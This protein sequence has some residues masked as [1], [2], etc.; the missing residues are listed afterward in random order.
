MPQSF[1]ALG[2]ISLLWVIVGFSLCFGTSLNGLIGDPRTYGRPR[3]EPARGVHGV[4][5]DAPVRLL[6]VNGVDGLEILRGGPSVWPPQRKGSGP[7]AR[8]REDVMTKPP[9][10]LIEFLFPFDPAVQSIALG[11]RKVVLEEMAPCHEYIFR[12]PERVALLYGATERVLKDC[13]CLVSVYAKHVNLGFARGA[14]LEDGAGVLQGTGKRMRHLTVKRLS[15]LDRPEIRTYLRRARKHA[16]LKRPRQRTVDDV[17]TVVKVRR[18][19][20]RRPGPATAW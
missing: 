4:G 16:G 15:E 8:W 18:A 9:R 19:G 13:I 2:V 14:E 20:A 7:D 12:M 17:V 3:P 10:E 6:R 1:I 5:A 11:L